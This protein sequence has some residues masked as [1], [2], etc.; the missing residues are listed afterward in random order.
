M[1]RASLTIHTSSHIGTF[2]FTDTLLPL[3]IK[4]SQTDG[5]DVRIVNVRQITSCL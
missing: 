3:L 2:V 4:T 5:A 1:C